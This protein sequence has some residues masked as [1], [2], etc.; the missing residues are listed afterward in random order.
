MLTPRQ[1]QRTIAT[2]SIPSGWVAGAICMI[3]KEKLEKKEMLIKEVDFSNARQR[4]VLGS[5][6]PCCYANWKRQV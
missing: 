3:G 5:R 2:Q 1:D 4:I 6:P